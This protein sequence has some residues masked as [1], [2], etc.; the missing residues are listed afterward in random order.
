M[1]SSA[2]RRITSYDT[3]MLTLADGLFR[4][5]ED[6]PVRAILNAITAAHGELS[7]GLSAQSRPAPEAVA[8]LA[9][10]QLRQLRS[11]P[12]SRVAH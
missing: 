9:A 10:D 5:Y 11:E 2:P 3:R 6:L 7:A 1:M 4:E 12:E 8:T